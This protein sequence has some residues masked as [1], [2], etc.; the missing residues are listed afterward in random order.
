MFLESHNSQIAEIIHSFNQLNPDFQN[1]IVGQIKKLLEMNHNYQE[2]NLRPSVSVGV[3]EGNLRPS[4]SV[5]VHKDNDEKPEIKPK[6]TPPVPAKGSK[7]KLDK[8]G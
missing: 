6:K 2:G 1:F 8:K 5:G 7:S 4:V 3:Q